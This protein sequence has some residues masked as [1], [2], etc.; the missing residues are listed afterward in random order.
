MGENHRNKHDPPAPGE[1]IRQTGAKAAEPLL[2][3]TVISEMNDDFGRALRCYS[4]DGLTSELKAA[5]RAHIDRLE[6]LYWRI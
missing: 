6:E 5:L 3:L 1:E 2:L 4:W